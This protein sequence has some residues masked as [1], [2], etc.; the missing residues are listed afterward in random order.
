M[1]GHVLVAPDKFK[2]SLSAA[3]VAAHVAAGLARARPEVPLVRLP[4]ADGGDGTVDAAVACG[5][6]EIPTTVSGPTGRPVGA[7]YAV[8]GETAVIELA[9]AS[10]LRFGCP[11]ERPPRWRRPATAWAS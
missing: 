2:G 4:V 8:R 6:T 7:R 10:G 9:E 1:Q 11:A 5:F 3:E